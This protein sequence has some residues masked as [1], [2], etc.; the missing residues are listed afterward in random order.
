MQSRGWRWL[1]LGAFHSTNSGMG[2]LFAVALLAMVSPSL[3]N[4]PLIP[5]VNT[6]RPGEYRGSILGRTGGITSM[7]G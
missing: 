2:S 1:A 6:K 7:S 3:A 4:S 5:G